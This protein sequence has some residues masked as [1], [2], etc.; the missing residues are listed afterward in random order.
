VEIL[1][2][3]QDYL[4]EFLK[5]ADVPLMEAVL[6]RAVFGDV[7][8]DIRDENLYIAHFSLYHA[9]YNL[10][11]TKGNEGY[12]F[13]LDPMRIR[14]LLAVERGRC[15][16]YYPDKG[17]FCGDSS[18][19]ENFCTDHKPRDQKI[20]CS[21]S[22]DVLKD[23]YENPENVNFG[24]DAILKKLSNGIIL[25]SLR[26]GEVDQAKVFFGID[27]PDKKIVVKKYRE[28]ALK[29]HPDRNGGNE[30]K[31]RELNSHYQILR[32]VFIL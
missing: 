15:G 26:K 23:F 2:V 14:M 20:Y 29:Y 3:N 1:R 32:E 8:I 30:Q 7:K 24:M 13:H 17:I 21:A 25:Y 27:Y 4:F 6:L 12:Y 28:L 10:K 9:L 18:D 19:D 16:Y 31:M 11:L 5:S 22:F